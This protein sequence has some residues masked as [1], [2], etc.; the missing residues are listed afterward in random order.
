[1]ESKTRYSILPEWRRK[2]NEILDR[3]AD[4]LEYALKTLH[5]PLADMLSSIGKRIEREGGK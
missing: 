2:L 3:E 5:I 1:M 4:Q